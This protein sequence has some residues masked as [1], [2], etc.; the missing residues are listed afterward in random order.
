DLAVDRHRVSRCDGSERGDIDAHIAAAGLA[1]GDGGVALVA[2]G[3]GFG[4]R[5]RTAIEQEEGNHHEDG[6]YDPTPSIPGRLV[7]S[8]GVSVIRHE[9]L[10]YVLNCAKPAGDAC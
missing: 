10:Y 9:L 1:L 2:S 8:Q 6:H 3:L 7:R 4:R 5:L